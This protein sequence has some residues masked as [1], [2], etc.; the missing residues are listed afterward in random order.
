MYIVM[1]YSTA[2]SMASTT[3]KYETWLT[4]AVLWLFIMVVH[5][6]ADTVIVEPVV[7]AAVLFISPNVV[8]I[9]LIL[10]I[11]LAIVLIDL[12]VIC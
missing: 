12:Y 1:T 5:S 3:M 6:N 8:M 10:I 4:I 2:S 7:R 11:I 9:I